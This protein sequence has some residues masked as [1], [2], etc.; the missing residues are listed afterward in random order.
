MHISVM[1]AEV[2][3]YLAVRPDGIYLDATT[4]LGG[5]TKLIAEQLTS[6]MVIA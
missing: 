5:H 4:G 2:L 3:E 6:G 1:P